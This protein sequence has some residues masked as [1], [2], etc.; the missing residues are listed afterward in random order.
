MTTAWKNIQTIVIPT[1]EESNSQNEL[2]VFLD[3]ISLI[4]F[5]KSLEMT[6]STTIITKMIES[7]LG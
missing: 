6:V 1:K 5:W 3:T 4:A 7:E 2:P